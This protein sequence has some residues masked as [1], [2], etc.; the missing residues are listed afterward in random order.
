MAKHNKLCARLS[1]LAKR[2]KWEVLQEKSY[3]YHGRKLRPDLV[4]I[5]NGTAII[6]DATVRYELDEGS[7]HKATR[8]KASK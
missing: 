6:V 1:E 3:V 4:L 5:K 7:L 2:K 8:E